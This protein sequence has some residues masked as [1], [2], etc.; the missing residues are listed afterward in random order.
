VVSEGG[1]LAVGEVVGTPPPGG[2]TLS[3]AFTHLKISSQLIGDHSVNYFLFLCTV[4]QDGR[5][6]RLWTF[7]KRDKK[8][9]NE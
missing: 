2:R 3:S 9:M 6:K 4:V 5:K 8:L 7:C 1:G